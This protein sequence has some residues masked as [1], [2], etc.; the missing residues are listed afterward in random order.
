MCFLAWLIVAAHFLFWGDFSMSTQFGNTLRELRNKKG[1]TQAQVAKLLGIDRTTFTKYETGKSEP[2]FD[3]LKKIG[4]IFDVDCNTLLNDE[5]S[6]APF[7][8]EEKS[9]TT[10]V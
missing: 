8:C 7:N 1:Y 10:Q 4:E 9:K 3:M 6:T 5:R 2:D